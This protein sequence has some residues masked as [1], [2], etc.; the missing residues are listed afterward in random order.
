MVASRHLWFLQV[1]DHVVVLLKDRDGQ[2]V[3]SF[4]DTGSGGETR[5]G[6]V[7]LHQHAH[8]AQVT[9]EGSQC[10][11]RGSILRALGIHA[12]AVPKEAVPEAVVAVELLEEQA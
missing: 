8:H 6:P 3:F 7:L 5:V 11:G 2:G 9:L 10:D 12:S 4:G 1:R